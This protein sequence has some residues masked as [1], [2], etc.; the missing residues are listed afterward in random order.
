MPKVVHFT[1]EVHTENSS[2]GKHRFGDAQIMRFW[3]DVGPIST[4][5]V[6]I[7]THPFLLLK[8]WDGTLPL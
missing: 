7:E 8:A 3:F 5:I 2:V 1:Q 6:V 4:R